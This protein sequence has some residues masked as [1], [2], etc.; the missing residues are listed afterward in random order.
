VNFHGVAV[1]QINRRSTGQA[2]QQEIG[3][4]HLYSTQVIEVICLAEQAHTAG[5]TCTLQQSDAITDLGKNPL[6]AL[7]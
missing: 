5:G 7:G 2:V 1:G 6:A 3:V 4:R